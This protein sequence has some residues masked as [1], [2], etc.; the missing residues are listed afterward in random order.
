MAKLKRKGGKRKSK[1]MSKAEVGANAVARNIKRLVRD[2]NGIT[3]V[4]VIIHLDST[5]PA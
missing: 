1:K 4:E 5:R 2:L 3:K